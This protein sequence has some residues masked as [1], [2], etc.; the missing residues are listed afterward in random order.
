M[1]SKFESRYGKAE[2]LWGLEVVH[3]LCLLKMRRLSF[4]SSHCLASFLYSPKPLLLPSFHKCTLS[5]VVP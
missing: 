4:L 2:G 3:L 1:H 5:G